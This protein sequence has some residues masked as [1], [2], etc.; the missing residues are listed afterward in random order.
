MSTS[1][2]MTIKDIARALEVSTDT[3]KRR[4]RDLHLEQF[5]DRFSKRPIRY[6]RNE[7][8]RQLKELDRQVVF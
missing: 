6:R 1:R 3:V 4:A 8:E 5:R 2:Y 7:V